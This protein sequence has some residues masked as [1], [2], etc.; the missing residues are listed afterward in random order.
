MAEPKRVPGIVLLRHGNKSDLP[1]ILEGEMIYTDDTHELFVKIGGENIRI[2]GVTAEEF[3]EHESEVADTIEDV[4]GSFPNK[5]HVVLSDSL[6]ASSS[7]VAATPNAVRIV[8]EE[9]AEHA[10]NPAKPSDGNITL[11][12]MNDYF[13]HVMVCDDINASI[14]GTAVVPTTSVVK[15]AYDKAVEAY[16]KAAEA[17][18]KIANFMNTNDFIA[19]SEIQSEFEKV[20]AR[21][22]ALE[23]GVDGPAPTL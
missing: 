20:Y 12:N 19:V 23:G 17:Y 7:G 22:A 11:E 1:A 13:G 16:N 8:H 14:G 4:S 3:S 18:D 9:F 2:N 5:G 10:K 21:L 6:N 15:T